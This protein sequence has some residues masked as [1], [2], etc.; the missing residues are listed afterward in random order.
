MFDD[1]NLKDFFQPLF[2]SFEVNEKH[3]D[4]CAEELCFLIMDD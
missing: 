3:F 4:Y 2:L 1:Q